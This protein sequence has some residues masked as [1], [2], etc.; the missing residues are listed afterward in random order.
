MM[1]NIDTEGEMGNNYFINRK[2]KPMAP[3]Q[4]SACINDFGPHV[5]PRG[6]LWLAE[7]MIKF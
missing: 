6:V 1:G 7:R 5:I 2:R 3:S 4:G